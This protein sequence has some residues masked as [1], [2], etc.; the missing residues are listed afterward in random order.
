MTEEPTRVAV[1]GAG[2]WGTALAGLLAD[3]HRVR[4]WAFEADVARE[5]RERHENESY[6]PGVSL[7]TALE[8]TSDLQEAL[9]G[10]TV[11]LSVTPAQHTRDVLARAAPLVPADALLVCASKGIETHRLR[12]MDE[13]FSEQFGSGAAERFAV[14]S[15]PSFAREVAVGEPTAVVVAAHNPETAASIQSV[16][17]T[18]RFRVYTNTDVVGVELGG[19]LKNV[20]ALAAGVATGLGHGHNTR[21]AL[22]TRG[23][24]EMARL[25]QRMGAQRATFAGLAGLGDLVLTCTG[26]LSR[27]RTVGVRLGQGEALASILSDMTAVAEGVATAAAV[28]ALAGRHEVEMPICAEV[29][30]MLS[31]GRPPKEALRNLMMRDPKPELWQ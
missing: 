6:L 23:L 5:V 9:D 24:A 8:A 10:A 20:I 26:D 29:H 27:N 28:V 21:A 2:S 12:R 1:L 3:R 16:F 22:I 25:G 31:D 11:V 15:G 14:L 19:A 13:V 30:A 18:D 17:Q 4:L 7:P